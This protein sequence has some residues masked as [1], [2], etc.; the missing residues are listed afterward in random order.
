MKIESI[1][2]W[3]FMKGLPKYVLCF[4]E[5]LKW[6]RAALV[7]WDINECLLISLGLRS[8]KFMNLLMNKKFI[9]P[10]WGL[11]NFKQNICVIIHVNYLNINLDIVGHGNKVQNWLSELSLGSGRLVKDLNWIRLNIF[12]LKFI[13]LSFIGIV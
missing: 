4:F 9:S 5:L 3:S 10:F 11:L 8:K 7:N 13:Y 2:S 1:K 6:M 12:C